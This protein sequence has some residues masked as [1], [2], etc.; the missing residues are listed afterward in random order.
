MLAEEQYAGLARQ[1]G[2]E[3][4]FSATSGGI[5]GSFQFAFVDYISAL[6]EKISTQTGRAITLSQ[7]ACNIVYNLLGTF[8]VLQLSE[9]LAKEPA[10]KKLISHITRLEPTLA[11]DQ[12]RL[13]IVDVT[14]GIYQCA[15]R[16]WVL[17]SLS[18]QFQFVA[19]YFG[20]KEPVFQEPPITASPVLA[21]FLMERQA[22][23]KASSH[24]VNLKLPAAMP[25]GQ[26]VHVAECHQS[27]SSRSLEDIISEFED[28][29]I[30]FEQSSGE[31]SVQLPTQPVH[32]AQ[33]LRERDSL[34]KHDDASICST[35]TSE[36]SI[37]PSKEEE[38]PA[39]L[40]DDI[41][42]SIS[43]GGEQ[44]LR[45]RAVVH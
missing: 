7:E 30:P 28:L 18:A 35:D 10:I 9:V 44:V 34:G 5:S 12:L 24:E 13:I 16:D 27:T 41:N 6:E 45:Q 36:R 15:A 39:I 2:I 21:Q 4:T 40:L 1:L 3:E 17:P 20:S 32:L 38:E 11:V 37:S 25:E 14:S 26:Q 8:G 19:D 31:H 29:G 22:S 42:R 33:F 43:L 23:A